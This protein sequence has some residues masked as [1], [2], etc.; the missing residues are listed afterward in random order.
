MFLIGT[1][2][3]YFMT[4]YLFVFD[5]SLTVIL[6]WNLF[7]LCIEWNDGKKERITEAP[8]ADL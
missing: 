4:T 5:I 8:D 3:N 1:N 2:G 6:V 7:G